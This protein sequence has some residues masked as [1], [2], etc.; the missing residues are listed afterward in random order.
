MHAFA[1]V[2]AK[3]SIENDKEIWLQIKAKFILSS[4]FFLITKLIYE[5]HFYF[6]RIKKLH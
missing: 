4:I 3:S 6:P 2:Q 1:K 5:K